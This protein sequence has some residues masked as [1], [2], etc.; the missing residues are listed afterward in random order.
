M[1]NFSTLRFTQ[2]R[3]LACI[4]PPQEPRASLEQRQERK[5]L[6]AAAIAL[7]WDARNVTVLCPFCHKTHRHSID[8]FARDE[9]S[10]RWIRD[11]HGRY[12]YDGSSL[13]RCESR[14]SHCNHDV[15]VD[16]H[17]TILFP[18]EDDDR[19]DGLS[20]EIERYSVNEEEEL[21]R[22]RT[23]GLAIHLPWQS[24]RL[25]H[26]LHRLRRHQWPQVRFRGS[27]LT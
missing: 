12:V 7:S 22:Y 11:T 13:T 24:C 1:W 17:Y 27:G 6:E 26:R 25:R 9:E 14:T 16:I 20:F 15:L 21:E 3:S 2:E 4:P 18:F 23:I 19:V 10:G 8:H 5:Q